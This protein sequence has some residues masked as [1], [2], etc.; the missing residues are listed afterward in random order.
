MTNENNYSKTKRNSAEAAAYS[1]HGNFT[2]KLKTGAKLYKDNGEETGDVFDFGM[3]QPYVGIATLNGEDYFKL[4]NNLMVKKSDVSTFGKMASVDINFRTGDTPVQLYDI[5]GMPNGKTIPPHTRKH[6]TY[7]STINDEQFYN[8]TDDDLVKAADGVIDPIG[9]VAPPTPYIAEA[10]IHYVPSY[11]VQIWTQEH[12]PVKN[13]NG[14]PKKLRHGVRVKIYAKAKINGE[15]YYS[16]GED[17]WIDS[18]YIQ[19]LNK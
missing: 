10:E 12:E 5:A 9:T 15:L 2:P 6:L 1:A 13:E 3:G 8:Y 11:T 4:P 14:T 17:Q 7:T 16:I 19:I 18:A